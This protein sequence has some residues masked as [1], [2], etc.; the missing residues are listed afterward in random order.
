VI[1]QPNRLIIQR[2]CYMPPDLDTLS[3]SVEVTVFGLRIF[4]H[5]A[6]IQDDGTKVY[7]TEAEQPL[8]FGWAW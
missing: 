1:S 7:R 6:W 5:R 2:R 4:E 3:C 8:P